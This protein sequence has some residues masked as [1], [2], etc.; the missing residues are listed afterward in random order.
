M[1]IKTI[2]KNHQPEW[3]PWLK[4]RLEKMEGKEVLVDVNLIKNIRSNNANRYYWACLD[5]ISQSLGYQPDELH[6]LFKGLYLPKREIKLNGKMYYLSG[7]T[8]Q[9]TTSQFMDYI[10]RIRCEMAQQGIEL[11]NPEDYKKGLDQ[12]IMLKEI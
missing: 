6:S 11:P 10:E 1:K 3:T 4:S 8:T 2:I 5:I 9:L 12:I 7:T